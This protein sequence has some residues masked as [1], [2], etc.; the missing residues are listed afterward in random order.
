MLKLEARPADLV[1]A[2][3]LDRLGEVGRLRDVLGRG[4]QPDDRSREPPGE[5]PPDERRDRDRHR[6]PIAIRP[7][8]SPSSASSI[9]ARLRATCT[10]PNSVVTR[11]HAVVVATHGDLA[12][13]PTRRCLLRRPGRRRR[14]GARS[15]RPRRSSPAGR[16]S[17]PGSGPARRLVV[18]SRVGFRRRSRGPHRSPGG[19]ARRRRSASDLA[20]G[21][22]AM[23]LPAN[24][25]TTPATR[26]A[27]TSAK[28]HRR[29]M[30]PAGCSRIL[31]RCG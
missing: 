31:A 22:A 7:L 28:R 18:G 14:R 10:A 16:G 29:L 11:E 8:R 3:D 24:A 23:R 4:R 20:P 17:G 19:A 21:R 27:S 1:G 26:S 2:L 13:D 15:R 25:A 30:G 6:A 9:S 12:H 5:P